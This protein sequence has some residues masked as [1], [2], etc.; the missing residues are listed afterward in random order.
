[1]ITSLRRLHRNAS[2]PTDRILALINCT[3]ALAS[4][5]VFD[6]EFTAWAG[7]MAER[8]IK[9]GQF[10]EIVQIGAVRLDSE[11]LRET[12]QFEM[13]VK[14]RLNPVLST[15][16]ET[17]TGITNVELASRSVDLA[18]AYVQFLAFVG[19]AMTFAFGRDDLIFV[20]NFRLYGMTGV[21][22]PPY[23]N[24]VHWLRA[25]GLD[26]RHAGDVAE[27]AGVVLAGRKH[28]ALF[29]ARAVTAGIRALVASGASNPFLDGGNA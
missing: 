23:Q 19:D 14:P 26:P 1:M 12:A 20:E 2:K 11:T 8:W 29:D 28:D 16:F 3:S 25:Q 6:L 17:L 24:V 5:I 13:L 22:L 4:V 9:P 18:E 27:A 10:R 7:S 15:Y 21:V